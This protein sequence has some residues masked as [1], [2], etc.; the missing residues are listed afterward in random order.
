MMCSGEFQYRQLALA[1]AIAMCQ[2]A[3]AQAE[4]TDQQAD[5]QL[6]EVTVQSPAA[7]SGLPDNLPASSSGMS[8]DKIA[9]TVNV[10]STEDTVKYLPNVQV[11]KRYIGDQN[12][13]IATRTSGQTSSARALLY[14]DDILLSNLLGNNYAYPPR[15]NL[16]SPDEIS[17]VDVFYGPFSAEYPGNSIG[18]VIVLSTRMPEK[19]EAHASSTLFDES[20]SQY[21]T[22]QHFTG[23]KNAVM[24]GDR[25]DKLAW[26]IEAGHLDSLGHPATF[27]AN[28]N[29]Y[30]GAS[31]ATATSGAVSDTDTTGN[32]RLI[33]GAT[34]AEH[35][36]QDNANLK[37]SYDLSP[38]LKLNYTLGYW[39]NNSTVGVDSYLRD[40]NGNPVYTGIVNI[41]G[42]K[43][44][45]ANAFQPSKKQQEHLLNALSFKTSTDGSWDWQGTV[46]IYDFS[47]D[48]QRSANAGLTGAGTITKLDG[49][50]WQTVDL[51]GDWR[52]G[53]SLAS[54]HQ[55]R[56]GYHYDHYVLNSR[57][58]A[59]SDWQNG[60][61]GNLTAAF[62]GNTQL[63][64]VFAQ[65]TWR[66]RPGTQ[67]II[68]G[69]YEW[70]DAYGGA[71][72]TGSYTSYDQNRSQQFFSPKAAMLFDL[73]EQW[74]LR[75]AYGR[76]YRTPTVAELFQGTAASSNTI[77]NNNPNLKAERADTGEITA[78][79]QLNGGTL[80]LTA[81][82][83]ELADALLSQTNTTVTP[84]VTNIQNIDRVRTNGL[85]LAW[86]QSD[87]GLRGLDVSA[88]LTYAKSEIIANGN[89]PASV[90]NPFP[91]IPEWRATAVVSYR[92]NDKLSY[93]LAARYSSFQTSDVN[94]TVVNTDVYGANSAYFIMDTR[95]SYKLDRQFTVAVGVDNL[96]NYKS[97]AYH[98]MPQRTTYA[99]LKFDY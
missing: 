42:Q 90:G 32:K 87:I 66:L 52:P 70:W 25:Q 97:Y 13:I 85:E 88:S 82:R 46:S 21:K 19:F 62:A 92:Q 9:Q 48:T 65:D 94:N 16:V 43:Y 14:A 5:K 53:G 55:L 58:Y 95:I 38:T 3:H 73:N 57:S 69:R 23:S 45:L 50:G 37:L 99:Q 22:S 68:G 89:N 47:K 96:N 18:S 6:A 8:A 11:R 78:T 31:A 71:T 54:E 4:N 80:R 51:K 33:I 40:A 67:L 72:T 60:S 79:R 56:F 10:T 29:K 63:N 64:A 20:F 39:Q 76:A 7:S 30:S 15:W 93:S 34:G 75:T 17:H 83:E 1:V 24:L 35:S 81:F 77:V 61:Q 84:N 98:P 49:T 91:G 59:T 28:P 26:I 74:T 12:S 2:V 44:N 27:A 36:I 86:E 41:N